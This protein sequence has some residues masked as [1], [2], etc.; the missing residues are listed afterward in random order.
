MEYKHW[1]AAVYKKNSCYCLSRKY[2]VRNYLIRYFLIRQFFG[3][4]CFVKW[5]ISIWYGAHGDCSKVA[6]KPALRAISRVALLRM[7]DK[8][9][10]PPVSFSDIYLAAAGGFVGDPQ[11][12]QVLLKRREQVFLLH[13]GSGFQVKCCEQFFCRI[14][15]HQK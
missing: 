11:R 12:D 2:L 10:F 4:R 14:M 3:K 7:R 9:T 5:T 13:V 1:K 8:G 6:A 15:N